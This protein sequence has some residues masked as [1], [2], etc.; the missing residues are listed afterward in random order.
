MKTTGTQQEAKA[1]LKKYR[2]GK[3]T[4]REEEQVLHW[5]YSFNA[6]DEFMHD[7]AAYRKAADHIRKKVLINIRQETAL[8]S[9]PLRFIRTWG[10]MAAIL[11]IV[12]SIGLFIHQFQFRSPQQTV[13]NYKQVNTLA[14]ERKLITLSDGSRIW[15]NNASTLKYPEVFAAHNR[16]VHLKGEAFFEVAKRKDKPF[17]IHTPQLN[18]QVLG[19]SFDIKA[20]HNETHETVTVA[21]G[22]VVVSLP[23]TKQTL[24][25]LKG[26]QALYHK[27]NKYLSKTTANVI[28]SRNW[29]NNI[30]A[31]KYET[32]ENISHELER[33][34][35]VKFV[36]KN[37][38]LL[39][40]RYTLKQK[41]ESLNNVM[42]VLSAGEFNYSI[43]NGVVTVW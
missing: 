33:W 41:D 20:F 29:Q 10:S 23:G 24:T 38:A 2:A 26:D 30:L 42:K 36:F 32:M 25:L 16:I 3:C 31:F 5:Y 22:K 4:P 34:Y 37:K 27:Q 1:L 18:V 6:S 39:H 40:K 11:G 13:L 12:I 7:E 9:F 14:G 17:I 8:S 19:T 21:T 35:G 15:L 28:E 43:T